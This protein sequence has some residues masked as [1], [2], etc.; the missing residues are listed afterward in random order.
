[1]NTAILPIL[2]K[3]NRRGGAG[4]YI[5]PLRKPWEQSKA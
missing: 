4:L 5:L 2:N 3:L 1:M